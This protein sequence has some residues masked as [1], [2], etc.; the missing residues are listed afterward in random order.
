[1]F[2]GGGESAKIAVWQPFLERRTVSL[3]RPALATA[4]PAPITPKAR[5]TCRFRPSRPSATR[6][7]DLRRRAHL[8][9]NKGEAR[10]ALAR[11]RLFLRARAGHEARHR[12]DPDLPPTG[13]RV[14]LGVET[15]QCPSDTIAGFV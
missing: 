2:I 10:N 11:A 1:M 6:R 3:Q 8:G 12:K 15:H 5:T 13:T 14:R 7:A 9:L 4:A